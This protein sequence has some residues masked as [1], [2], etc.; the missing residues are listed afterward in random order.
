MPAAI[1]PVN[2][3][4]VCDSP[5]ETSALTL[6]KPDCLLPHPWDP[7]DVQRGLLERAFR[8]P[9]LVFVLLPLAVSR[10][11]LL[12]LC[13]ALIFLN[14][15][16][17]ERSPRILEANFACIGRLVLIAFGVWPGCLRV[18]GRPASPPVPVQVVAPHV[19]LLDAFFF[20]YS[21]LPRPIA[22]EP[23]TKIPVVSLI[24]R[25]TH[26]IAVPLPRNGPRKPDAGGCEPRA[27]ALAT[28]EEGH[29]PSQKSSSATGAVRTAIQQHKV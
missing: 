7:A 29:V 9:L 18:D 23:Y 10:V 2:S 16:C 19:G 21:G 3:A 4:A 22:L 20:L 5:P 1:Q 24:F 17:F 13:S 25:V 26:G 12:A 14:I 6:E 15:A 27:Q 28:A 11:L 8:V